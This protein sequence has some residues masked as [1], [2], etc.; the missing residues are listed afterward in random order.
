MLIGSLFSGYGGLDL[1]VSEVTGATVAW[2]CEWEDA[3][4][5]ILERNFPGVPNYRDVTKVDWSAVEPVDIL[6]GGFPCQDV[7]LAGRRAGMREGTRSGLWSEFARAIDTL[8]PR[9]VVIENVRG[10][11][12]ARA[13]GPVEWCSGC[14]GDGE[15][16]PTLRALGAVL[17]DLADLGYDA[18]WLGLRASDAGAPHARFR[19]FVIAYPGRIGGGWRTATPRGGKGSRSD[20]Q[21]DWSDSGPHRT[22]ATDTDDERLDWSGETRPGWSEPQDGSDQ[23]HV[24]WGEYAPAIERWE[25]LTKRQAP[26]P[27]LPDGSKGQHRLSARFV[28]WMMGLPDGWVT[29]P[30]IGISRNDQIK[31]LGNG[32]VPQQ[33]RLALETLLDDTGQH[34]TP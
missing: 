34:W 1:A 22:P 33:A 26:P 8:R 31:A 19:I 9:L 21:A 15:D 6:T 24:A 12:S 14:M 10:L 7:S 3:P 28:E 27:T 32:V 4:S 16:K 13:D 11:L 18:R 5:A 17:G 25:R 30:S 20:A 29:D 23:H 2:H